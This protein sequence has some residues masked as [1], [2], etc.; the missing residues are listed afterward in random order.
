[1]KS[2]KLKPAKGSVKN[3]KRVARGQGSGKGGTSTRGHK[4]AKSRSGYSEK[5]NFEGGQ[6][7]IQMRLPKRGFKNTHRRYKSSNPAAYTPLNLGVLE[8]IAEKYNLTEITPAVLKQLKIVSKNDRIKILADGTVSKGLE[9]S[10]HA[11]SASA[12]EAIKGAGGKTFIVLNTDQVQGVAHGD[13][14]ENVDVA[15][16]TK[17]FSTIKEGDSVH[18]VTGGDMTVKFNL[19]VNKIDADAKGAIDAVGG[20]VN[21]L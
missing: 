21:I 10:A 2:H 19:S 14:L 20:T 8:Q 13:Q 5:R 4:G 7:P 3:R 17:H 15:I 16:L 6:M 18:V 11:F 12:K 1:M 9:V